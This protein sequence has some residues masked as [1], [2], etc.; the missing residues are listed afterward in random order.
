MVDADQKT[1]RVIFYGSLDMILEFNVP[2]DP[3]WGNMQGQTRLLA[4]ITP[5]VTNGGDA[6]K[7]LTSYRTTTT[8]IITDLQAISSVVG[9]VQTRKWWGII[10]RSGDYSR[11]IFIDDNNL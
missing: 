7:K 5:C 2:E 6:A 3:F 4:A 11:T 10:D 8:Q 9:R 1:S